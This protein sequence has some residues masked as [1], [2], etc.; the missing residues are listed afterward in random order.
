MIFSQKRDLVKE[1]TVITFILSF[2]RNLC[3]IIHYGYEKK[4]VLLHPKYPSGG[5]RGVPSAEDG[6]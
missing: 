5:M 2:F 4:A 6:Q 3:P 1:K